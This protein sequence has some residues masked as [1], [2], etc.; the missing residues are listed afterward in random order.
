MQEFAVLTSNVGAQFDRGMGAIV[1]TSTRAGSNECHGSA[2]E[3][4]RNSYVDAKNYFVR[5][6]TPNPPYKLNDFGGRLGGPILHNKTFFFVNYEGYYERAASTLIS[7]VP[8]LAERPGKFSRGSRKSMILTTTKASGST[9]TRTQFTNNMIPAS[10]FDPVA[11]QLVNAYPAPQTTALSNNYISYPL[12]GS[13]D[14]RGDVR[15]D[16]QITASQNLFGRYSIDDTQIDMPNTYNNVIGGNENSFSGH[17]AD[18]GQQGVVGYNK[19]F[20]P[21]IVG[22]YRFGFDDIPAFFCLQC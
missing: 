16:H 17:Q 7:T 15:I 4:L 1:V 18:R 10:R 21:S 20:T 8:T 5:P 11:V 19:V 14:N 2:Y 12:K 22:E 6:N 13:D 3:F 9:Y